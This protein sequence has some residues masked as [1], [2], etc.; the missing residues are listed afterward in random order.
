MPLAFATACWLLGKAVLRKAGVKVTKRSYK[1]EK[2]ERKRR[3]GGKHGG[4][5][6]RRETFREG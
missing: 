2:E 5:L 4:G 3:E 1:K 6:V